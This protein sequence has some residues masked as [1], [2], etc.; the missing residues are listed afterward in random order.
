MNAPPPPVD[1]TAGHGSSRK[2]LS[3]VPPRMWV[4]L[5]LLV[6]TVL[7]VAQNRDTAQI[8]F[9]VLSLTAPLWAALAV[10]VAAGVVIGLLVRPS[11]R[12]RRGAPG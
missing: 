4:A 10:S 6:V 8:Q 2:G 5:V 3:S 1:G 12:R 7:F 11:R 9:L